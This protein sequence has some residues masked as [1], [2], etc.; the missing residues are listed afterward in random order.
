M[1]NNKT[2]TTKEKS[3]PNQGGDIDIDQLAKLWIEMV[4]QQIQKRQS[5]SL[6]R[7]HKIIL[8]DSLDD[9]DNEK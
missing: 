4:L 8:I 7:V 3:N 6:K 1:K 9:Y 5:F 2:I